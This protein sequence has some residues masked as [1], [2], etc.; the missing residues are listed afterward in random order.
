[1]NKVYREL[2]T[3][4]KP[5]AF[6]L[7][8]L[9]LGGGLEFA[10]AGHYRVAADNPKIK[11]GLPESK[12]GLLPGAGGTQRLP[13]LIGVQNAAMMILQGADKSPQEAKGLGFINEV[14]PAG[15]NS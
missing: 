9:A 13:R 14:V 12:V 3:C 15:P 1:M 11:L 10:L 8:G 5:V 2:E 6:A 7:E 4:G